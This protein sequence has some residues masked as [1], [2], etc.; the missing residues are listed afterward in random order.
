MKQCNILEELLGT[1]NFDDV[2]SILKAIFTKTYPCEQQGYNYCLEGIKKKK[3]IEL[4][5]KKILQKQS[6]T[7]KKIRSIKKP[8]PTKN[9]DFSK[10]S[11]SSKKNYSFGQIYVSV[12]CCRSVRKS[13]VLYVIFSIFWQW[14][15]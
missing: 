7:H 13:Y 8:G 4:I 15:W 1:C 3:K 12:K 14:R 2:E 9:S 5:K 6:L 11:S 10:N